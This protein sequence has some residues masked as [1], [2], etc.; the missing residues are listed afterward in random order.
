MARWG[1]GRF[2]RDLR[3]ALAKMS[4]TK[5]VPAFSNCSLDANCGNGDPADGDPWGQINGF[6]LWETETIED[7]PDRWA[8]TVFLTADCFDD[9]CTVDL[10]PRHCRAFKP[11]AGEVFT[12]TNT[13]PAG[14]RAVQS[15][16]VKADR[17][18]LVTLRG[19]KVRKGA[20]DAKR[21]VAKCQN[22]IRI[23]RGR[24]GR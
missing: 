10:T 18:G 4:W 17:W 14:G 5:S 7:R 3:R 22:L 9:A 16:Q 13:D 2:G 21:R 23:T 8:M 11:K 12:W 24:R 20:V 1:G 19:L 15:G 6:L